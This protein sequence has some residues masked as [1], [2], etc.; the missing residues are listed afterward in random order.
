M[1]YKCTFMDNDSYTAGDVN[2]VMSH[3]TREGVAIFSDTG[4]IVSDLNSAIE[5]ITTSGVTD[6]SCKVIKDSGV[7][8]ITSGTCFMSDGS[9]ITFDSDGYEIEPIENTKS[10]VYLKREEANNTI[11]V[12]VSETAGDSDT[13]P[14][15]EISADGEVVDKR[16]FAMAK[17][18]LSSANI[19]RSGRISI[20]K[21]V[22][23]GEVVLKLDMGF[24]G[25][26]YFVV[27]YNF[28]DETRKYKRCIDLSRAGAHLLP[29]NI[30]FDTSTGINVQK[31]G[32]CLILTATR[33]GT[34]SC[35]LDFEVI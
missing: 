3:I 19:T 17:I 2:S 27:N 16:K 12:V 18:A 21:S 11:E 13:V 14:L 28:G 10:Y 20:Q 31:E 33:N 25:F 24:S 30:V 34:E 22:T 35:E 9:Q 4:D 26:K 7:Y 32:S 1:G 5:D 15:A 6:G 8:K 23:A 29:N